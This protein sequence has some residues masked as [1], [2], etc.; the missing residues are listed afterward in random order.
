MLHNLSVF[1]PRAP[2]VVRLQGSPVLPL[3]V[4]LCVCQC[5]FVKFTHPGLEWDGCVLICLS[6]RVS[7]RLL[8]AVTFSCLSISHTTASIRVFKPERERVWDVYLSAAGIRNAERIQS[9]SSTRTIRDALSRVCACVWERQNTHCLWRCLSAA[10][11][12]RCCWHTLRARL[13][14]AALEQKRSVAKGSW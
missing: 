10:V 11:W 5:V 3:C 13:A 9:S 14:S 4:C 12:L 6:V 7:P 1:S 8:L 2:Q